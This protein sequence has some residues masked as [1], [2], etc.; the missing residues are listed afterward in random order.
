V[1]A[2]T[3]NCRNKTLMMEKTMIKVE[4]I[5]KY[6]GRRKVLDDVTFTVNDGEIVGFVGLNGAG[7]TTT[8]R[9]IVGVL[10]PNS[11]D[12]FIDGISITK[13]K[14]N[15]SKRVGWV[16][17]LPIFELDA[18]ALDYFVYIAGYYGIGS[19]EAR[20]LGKRLFEELGLSGREKDKLKNYS[21]GMKKRFALAVSL[22]SDPKNFIFDEVLNGLDPQGIQFFRDLALKMKK[23]GKAVLFSSH[24]LSEVEAIADRVVFIHKGKILKEMSIEEIK[25]SVKTRDLKVVL[26]DFKP[27]AL[28][29]A[30]KFGQVTNNGN[31]IIIKDCKG[32]IPQVSSALSKYQVVEIN[33]LKGSLEEFFFK[34]I[35]EQGG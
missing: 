28:A 15:A 21:Q 1:L 2:I 18:S 16:P 31:V 10:E 29:E 27:E 30:S 6:F 19:S 32:D 3:L 33:W 8:I 13:D 4:R 11:G 34:I 26:G 35:N 25:K 9:V 12:V 14:R 17:E 23:E 7:K 22:I 5:T 20:E 24:I